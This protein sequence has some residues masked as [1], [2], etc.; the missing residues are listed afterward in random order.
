MRHLLIVVLFALALIPARARLG[1]TQDQC[2]QRYGTPLKVVEAGGDFN[3]RTVFYMK[4]GYTICASFIN[5]VCAMLYVA[6]ADN[7]EL[8]DNEQE[9]LLAAS[10]EG[11]KWTKADIISMQTVW[12]RDDG[13]KAQ[14][15]PLKHTLMFLSKA[16]M[17][18]E[19][20][21][22]KVEENKKLQGL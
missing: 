20:E 17:A 14:Y 12:N 3:Y 18:A 22:A 7:S 16:Y 6:K 21:R 10:S 9:A 1:E 15:E 5:G 4:N 19:T 8:S 11:K 2:N 13:A